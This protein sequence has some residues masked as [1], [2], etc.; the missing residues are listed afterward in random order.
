MSCCSQPS[1]YFPP[2]KPSAT[3]EEHL[4]DRLMDYSVKGVS[5]LN[6]SGSTKRI[7]ALLQVT[8]APLSAVDRKPVKFFP[9]QMHQWRHRLATEVKLAP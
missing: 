4:H 2:H 8:H 3:C 5:N 9:H 7:T 1:N 6:R